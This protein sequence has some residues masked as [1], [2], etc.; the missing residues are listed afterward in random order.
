MY[1]QWFEY[2]QPQ[3]TGSILSV[4]PSEKYQG[5]YTALK[6]LRCEHHKLHNEHQMSFK[7]FSHLGHHAQLSYNDPLIVIIRV[8][9]DKGN[10]E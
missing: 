3:A 4:E 7:K 2:P 1:M 9:L 5:E 6:K 8:W 10:T